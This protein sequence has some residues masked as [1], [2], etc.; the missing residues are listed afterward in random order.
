MGDLAADFNA[1]ATN[2]LLFYLNGTRISLNAS[3]IDPD[4]TLLDF[5][6][7]QGP[8]LTGTK[9]GCGEGGC[10]AC[11]VVIQSKHPRTGVLQH[12]AVNACLAPLVSVD[13][14]HVITVEGL[15]NSENPHPLQERM[16]KMSGSQCGFCTVSLEIELLC[17]SALLAGHDIQA[18]PY[19]WCS[20]QCVQPA[21]DPISNRSRC[22]GDNDLTDNFTPS[23]SLE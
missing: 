23:H 3:T 7:A 16:W 2:T 20:V 4:A 13:G 10:G 19:L 17:Q 1:Q 8:G 21:M 22:L 5:I 12:L 14:K 11:T 15:G 6:R 18:G 9:L